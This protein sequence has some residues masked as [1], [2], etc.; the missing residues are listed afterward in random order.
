MLI[1]VEYQPNAKELTRASL[2]FAEKKPFLLYTVGFLNLFTGLFLIIFIIKLFVAGLTKHELIASLIC[3]MW[4]FGRRPL[5]EWLLYYKMK[6]SKVLEKPI[7]VEMSLNGIVW[8][9]KGLRFGHMNWTELKYVI[10]AQNGFILPNTFTRF[11]WLPYHGFQSP[12]D[13]Q[14]LKDFILERQIVYRAFPSWKC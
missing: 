12:Q 10:E 2:L 3:A 14:T 9:G 13:I 7:T 8:S 6:N 4:I 11:L 1:K 5:N